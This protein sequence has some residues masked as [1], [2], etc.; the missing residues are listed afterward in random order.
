M[1]RFISAPILYCMVST[2]L[3]PIS[4]EAQD[5]KRS[6]WLHSALAQ[7]TET[8]QAP[9]TVSLA[10]GLNSVIGNAAMAG[11]GLSVVG[12]L[13]LGQTDQVSGAGGSLSQNALPT[14]DYRDTT[15]G[16]YGTEYRYN[17]NL[18]QLNVLP[19]N[20]Y[21]YDG[22][23]INVA[24]VDS[25]IDASHPE[26]L[27]STIR[28]YDFSNSATGYGGDPNGHGTHVASIIAGDADGTGMRGVA[29]DATLYSYRVDADGDGTFEA[30]NTD[31]Q[32][33][34]VARRHI[35]D[36]IHV[37]NNSWGSAT[38]VTAYTTSQMRS[39]YSRSIS[40]F[41][42]AQAAGTLFVSAAGNSGNSEVSEEAGLP[43]H[44]PELVDAWLV[45][46]ASD[47]NGVETGF[48][49]RC[50]VAAAF[51]VTAPGN[52]VLAAD[53]GTTGYV[54]LSG[55]SMAAP[56]VSGLAAALMEKFP[57]LTPKQI[58]TRI[59]TTASL[60]PLTGFFGETLANDGT[61]AMEAIFGHGLVDSGAAAAQIGNLTYALGPDVSRGQDLSQSKLALPA[62]VG[63]DLAKQ[64]MAD[65]F[66]VFDSFDNA[67]F[68][69]SGSQVFE[70]AAA[71]FVPSYGAGSA[72]IDATGGSVKARRALQSQPKEQLIFSFLQ[73][74]D[75]PITA[76]YW[77]GMA[78]LFAPQPFVVPAAKL[79][80]SWESRQ[81]S[82][83]SL[84]PFLSFGSGALGQ[85]SDR[86]LEIGLASKVRLGGAIDLISSI[87]VGEQA[88]NFGLDDQSDLIGLVKAEF[89]VNATLNAAN[90]FF[91]RYE[92]SRY[93]DR[94]ATESDFGMSAARADSWMMGVETQLPEADLTVGVRNDYALS[95]GTVSLMTPASMLKDGTILYDHKSYGLDRSVRLRP[96]VAVQHD[97]Y[98]G[99]LNF[100]ARFGS[101]DRSDLEG[102]ELSFSR[103][104]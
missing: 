54:A 94:A 70:A 42:D 72:I 97:T 25:G 9:F 96:F 76:D 49:N 64:I 58:A 84:M 95:Q 38:A 62:G 73:Q 27:N 40:A 89:G 26:F 43:Y 81:G 19:L 75:T 30:L 80:M 101:W 50:G 21:G 12:A 92:Q 91:L 5:F 104:F 36:N 100:G 65:D 51:C 22:T 15:Q 99:T 6:F 69:V 3:V 74:G 63:R 68:T 24:V 10:P 87:S 59:K 79:R 17:A 29:Y 35:T 45:V 34:A 33:A 37:S 20:N 44:A 85:G 47:E 103:Q 23:G 16:A 90:R 28:G 93:S 1:V 31:S 52:R 41:A 102:V 82:I 53:A 60:A 98:G 71:G 77:Q 2:V 13:A 18:A 32:L 57:N 8:R 14:G 7:A 88:I 48:T 11:I 46:V 83:S 39:I 67:M 66:V 61:A 4:A 78:A 56:F 55:T 86:S